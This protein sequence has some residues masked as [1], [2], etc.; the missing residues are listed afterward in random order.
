MVAKVPDLMRVYTD[1]AVLGAARS[2][3]GPGCDLHPHRHAHISVGNPES[4]LSPLSGWHKDPFFHE[5]HVR[6]KH[7]FHWVFAL[8]FP[9]PTPLE[10][11]GTGI[12]RNCHN[13]P[14][15][16]HREAK[17]GWPAEGWPAPPVHESAAVELNNPV[18]CPAGTV[19]FIHMDSWCVAACM[20]PCWRCSCLTTPLDRHR[21]GSNITDNLKRY[22]LKFHYVRMQE[23]CVTGP[24]WAHDPSQ[25]DWFPAALK[26]LTPRASKANWDWLC[27]GAPVS[28]EPAAL[29]DVASLLA[30]FDGP[31][32]TRVDAAFALGELARADA[33][34]V[35]ALMQKLRADGG[36]LAEEIAEGYAAS[37]DP[38]FNPAALRAMN[39]AESE[40]S[41]ALSAAGGAAVPALLEAL[42]GSASEPWWVS[43][44]AASVL[45]YIGNAAM[46]ASAADQLRIA[47]AL[48]AALSHEHLWVRRNAADALGVV[49]PTMHE[50]NGHSA[51]AAAIEGLAA[52]AVAEEEFLECEVV[53]LSAVTALARL[54]S[55][56]LGTVGLAAV[57]HAMH[58]RRP[59]RLSL[60]TRHYAAAALRRDGS[61][62]AIRGLVD[63]LMVSRWL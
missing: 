3:C 31:E 39:P 2:L 37:I 36:P 22:M 58:E 7:T 11:G 40:M 45:G 30:D 60:A 5:P 23:P 25:R 18:V 57:V 42:E 8:Y 28:T 4:H 16:N 41:K 46:E 50:L 34:V 29:G 38:G 55:L 27:G 49:V 12:L 14:G 61:P 15:I 52:I 48:T 6:H 21:T 56:G 9:Q 1:P 44:T 53:R 19:V 13:L 10:L 63:G 43:S 24:T 17:V 26:D 59:D 54:A 47:T 62:A 20:V 35:P 33:S 32:P 51:A